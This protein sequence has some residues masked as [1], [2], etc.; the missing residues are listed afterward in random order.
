MNPYL[1]ANESTGAASPVKEEEGKRMPDIR[2]LHLWS[3]TKHPSPPKRAVQ[4]DDP[5]SWDVTWFSNYE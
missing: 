2:S 5:E 3:V 4:P 1:P